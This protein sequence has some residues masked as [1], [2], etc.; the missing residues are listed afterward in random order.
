MLAG[1]SSESIRRN[2]RFSTA[3]YIRH[4]RLTERTQYEH[5][6]VGENDEA[7]TGIPIVHDDAEE[8]YCDAQ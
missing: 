5:L 8:R 2:N 6:R 1:V 3:T 7:V 4:N